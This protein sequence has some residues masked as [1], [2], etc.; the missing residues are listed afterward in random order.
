MDNSYTTIL[1]SLPS[2]KTLKTALATYATHSGFKPINWG[3]AEKVICDLLNLTTEQR[4]LKQKGG[5]GNN[6]VITGRITNVYCAWKNKHYVVKSSKE[7][8]KWNFTEEGRIF[9]FELAVKDEWDYDKINFTD[10]Y[11][12][13][14]SLLKTKPIIPE[15]KEKKESPNSLKQNF[16]NEVYFVQNTETKKIKIGIT[17]NLKSRLSALQTST[18]EK[19][20]VIGTMSGGEPLEKELHERFAADRLSGEWFN[21]SIEIYR[22][23]FDS[24]F[25]GNLW[26]NID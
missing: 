26:I 24:Y 18:A 9:I 1:E 8:S 15:L 25:N 13:L 3:D 4:T 21:D 19:L 17:K 16:G 11:L 5:T 10:F 12:N 22:F 2:Q 23:L 20:E 6:K 14:V 7:Q